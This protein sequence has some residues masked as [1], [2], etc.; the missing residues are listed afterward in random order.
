MVEAL[1]TG[2]TEM[3]MKVNG[4]IIGEMVKVSLILLMEIGRKMGKGLI[5][6]KVLMGGEKNENICIMRESTY[7]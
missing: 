4:I 7:F 2:M 5:E 6:W 3:C 1:F